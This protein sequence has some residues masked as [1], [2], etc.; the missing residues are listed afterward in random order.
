[1]NALLCV[2]DVTSV[3]I[4]ATYGDFVAAVAVSRC[5]RCA[6]RFCRCV[7]V[8]VCVDTDNHFLLRRRRL[9]TVDIFLKSVLLINW[10]SCD[11]TNAT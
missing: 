8:Y 5:V 2:R 1:M 10:A 3:T 9:K 7:C 11:N 6:A 4:S